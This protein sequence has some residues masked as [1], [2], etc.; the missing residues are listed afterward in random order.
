[1]HS[2]TSGPLWIALV[3]VPSVLTWS[4]GFLH[5]QERAAA[6]PGKE[7]RASS[8]PDLE[9]VLQRPISLIFEQI[10]LVD[11]VDYLRNKVWPNIV[12][13]VSTLENEGITDAPIS[14]DLENVPLSVA[15]DLALRPLGIDYIVQDPVLLITTE[16]RALETMY[17]RSYPVA[18]FVA[19]SKQRTLDQLLERAGVIPGRLQRGGEPDESMWASPPGMGAFDHRARR[20]MWGSTALSTRAVPPHGTA[21]LFRLVQAGLSG[22]GMGPGGAFGGISGPPL[23]EIAGAHG[24]SSSGQNA[25]ALTALI[26]TI[27]ASVTPDQWLEAGGTATITTYGTTLVVRH[28]RRGHKEIESLLEDLRRALNLDRLLTVELTWELCDAQQPFQVG[29]VPSRESSSAG[30]AGGTAVAGVSAL[31]AV[32]NSVSAAHQVSG[33]RELARL[34]AVLVPGQTIGVV[35]GRAHAVMTEAVPVV[36]ENVEAK[37]V[38]IREALDGLKVQVGVSPTGNENQF[39]LELEFHLTFRYEPSNSGPEEP[40][41]YRAG[42]ASTSLVVPLV[43]NGKRVPVALLPIDR[44]TGAHV[45]VSARLK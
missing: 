42:V 13:D 10:P 6:N 31:A 25:A 30:A 35:G 40:D 33:T 15:L 45:L 37:Q 20:G 44:D 18:D 4:A 29:N 36:A 21:P 22:G 2:R 34:A 14:I 16:R 26:D 27:K 24:E 38:V 43:A 17:M 1:M 41:T 28:N 7:P 39:L 19:A 32:E 3:L 9:S 11:F 8:T 23:K 12:I 5:G